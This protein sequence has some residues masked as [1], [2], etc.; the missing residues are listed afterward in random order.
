MGS[1]SDQKDNFCH[2][3]SVINC[4]CDLDED[5][6]EV[7]I[8]GRNLE[9]SGDRGQQTQEDLSWG[10]ETDMSD[11]GVRMNLKRSQTIESAVKVRSF[12]H[13]WTLSCHDDVMIICGPQL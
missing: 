5:G 9:T 11:V 2:L 13:I 1:S 10:E 4:S 6:T 8:G 12:R 7:E 3:P